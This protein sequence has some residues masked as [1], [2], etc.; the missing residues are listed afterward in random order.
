[1]L[2]DYRG[3]AKTKILATRSTLDQ[4]ID[5][6]LVRTPITSVEF[7]ICRNDGSWF[8][9]VF[10]YVSGTLHLPTILKHARKKFDETSGKAFSGISHVGVASYRQFH[11]GEE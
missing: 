10:V 1:M 2:L 9:Q 3:M 11:L 4:M 5:N 6:E 8:D 7:Y